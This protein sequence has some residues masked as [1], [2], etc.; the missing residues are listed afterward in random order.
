MTMVMN[1][2]NCSLLLQVYTHACDG[3]SCMP[4][5][6]GFTTITCVQSQARFAQV[7]AVVPELLACH[8]HTLYFKLV[9]LERWLTYYTYG[10]H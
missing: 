7:Q 2:A 5:G 9:Y 6:E 1:L 3:P 10:D 4:L 8:A